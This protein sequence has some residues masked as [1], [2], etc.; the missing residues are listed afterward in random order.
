MNAAVYRDHQARTHLVF[1]EGRKFVHAVALDGHV[2]TR[3]L[4]KEAMRYL[5]P[6]ELKGRPYPIARAARAL[7]RAGKAM[8]ITN[9]AKVVLKQLKE[10]A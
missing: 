7:L 9:T 2:C 5:R 8:G 3:A 1:K 6:M 10:A 4:P